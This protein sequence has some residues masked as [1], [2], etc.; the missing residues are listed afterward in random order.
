MQDANIKTTSSEGDD[1]EKS[2][3]SAK[4]QARRELRDLSHGELVE[5]LEQLGQPKFRAKQI[6]DWIWVK[7]AQSFDDM[8]NLPKSLRA[9]LAERC[10]LGGTTVAAQQVSTDGSRKYLL[11]F[12]DGVAVEC[13]GMPSGNRLAVCASTQAGCGMKCAFCATGA[14]GLTRNLTAS[15]IYEQVMHVR[16][17]FNTRVTSVVL[18]GQG[19]RAASSP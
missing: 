4:A 17:D 1:A 2:A 18:M 5:I 12:D 15:E 13:V 3:S 16:D 8:T 19:E 10:V 11:R 7:N 14:S 9:S 6:E